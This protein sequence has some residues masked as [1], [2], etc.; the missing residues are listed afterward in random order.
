MR[1]HW[2]PV[3]APRLIAAVHGGRSPF[4]A[5]EPCGQYDPACRSR[6]AARAA[7]DAAL[8][9]APACG[10]FG[11]PSFVVGELFR[12]NDRLPLPEAYLA[13]NA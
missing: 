7:H 12:G 8:A 13:D 1:V 5:P 2:L 4:A 9:E 6:D 3:A 11:V 10:A